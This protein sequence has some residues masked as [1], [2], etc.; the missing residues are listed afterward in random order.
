MRL[1]RIQ[2]AVWLLVITLPA[3]AAQNGK[4]L[5]DAHCAACHG[6]MGMGGVGV[7]LALPTFLEITPDDYLAKTIRLGRPGRV[8][9]AFPQLS[10]N[11]VKA[12]VKYIFTW[13]K[14]KRLALP[15]TPIKGDIKNGAILYKQNCA[16]CHGIN[17]EGGTGTGVNFSRR[18]NLPIIPPA[19]LNSGFLASASDQLIKMTLVKGRIGTP[20]ISFKEK[21][22]NDQQLN[23]IVAYVRNFEVL[24]GY[25]SSQEK[26]ADP[27]ILSYTSSSTFEQS[28][29]NIKQAIVDANFRLIKVQNIDSGLSN[30][31]KEDQKKTVIYFCNFN[32][33]SELLK[34][35]PRVG[36][37]LP[38]RVTIVETKG[39]VKIMSIN[40]K[41]LSQY[42][43]NDE[44][45]RISTLMYDM[46]RNILEE[47]TL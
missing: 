45:T 40:P 27:P 14:G 26:K 38:C 19:L 22:L 35:D 34:I 15:T 16:Q 36:V 6:N 17:G 20:M 46:Y 25:L 9:P 10:D 13:Y 7:P 8:M 24:L 39:T 29:E 3:F 32:I 28:V 41:I 23:D 43:N 44:L 31:N 5:Y 30:P 21:G 47:S 18:Q 4:Q 1:T 37:F 11:Q 42:F 33:V 2:T 12:I